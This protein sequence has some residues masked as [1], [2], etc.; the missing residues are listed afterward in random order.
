MDIAPT[1]NG[2]GDK[3]RRS[4][5]WQFDKAP[6][7][8]GIIGIIDS[9]YKASTETLFNRFLSK[10]YD[11][12]NADSFGLSVWGSLI[13]L[14][15]PNYIAAGNVVTPIS[16]DYYRRL[17]LAKLY[18][19]ST[20]YSMPAINQA[21]KIAYGGR[22]IAMTGYDQQG[23]GTIDHTQSGHITYA[24]KGNQSGTGPV[25]LTD[26]EK[27]LTGKIQGITPDPYEALFPNIALWAGA[28]IIINVYP[29]AWFPVSAFEGNN[30]LTE[31]S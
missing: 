22:F 23:N 24:I 6:H 9:F 17:L 29:N 21:I 2:L 14:P 13:G 30:T 12:A 3:I 16:D 4:I 10:T 26:E 11:L 7:L 20:N 25:A 31:A 1:Y 27:Y 8:I 28:G 19:M 15:R 18:L 5:T